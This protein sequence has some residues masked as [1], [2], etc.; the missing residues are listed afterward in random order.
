[1]SGTNLLLPRVGSSQARTRTARNAHVLVASSILT[2]PI[3][4]HRP[5]G[6]PLD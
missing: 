1:M 3:H 5:L 2:A 6:S 4:T